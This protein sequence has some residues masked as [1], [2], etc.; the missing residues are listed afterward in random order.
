MLH[1]IVPILLASTYTDN[2]WS[3]DPL[4]ST[5]IINTPAGIT[6]QDKRLYGLYQDNHVYL[7]PQIMEDK[8][9]MTIVYVHEYGHYIW[10]EKMTAKQRAEWENIKNTPDSFVSEYAIRSI[11]EDFAET[12]AYTLLK[13]EVPK[14]DILK[15]KQEFIQGVLK[16]I[17]R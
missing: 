4:K 2:G 5:Q 14:N 16:T 7:C 3:C 10:F 1:F 15:K 13:K 12:F 11:S 9:L 6:V 17:S 8:K